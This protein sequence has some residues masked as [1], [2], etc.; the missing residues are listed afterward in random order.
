ML[1]VGLAPCVRQR[2]DKLTGVCK[3]WHLELVAEW[4][5]P[6]HGGLRAVA[7]W[8]AINWTPMLC[9][10]A[11]LHCLLWTWMSGAA[12]VH[13]ASCHMCTRP[14][15]TCRPARL[16]PPLVLLPPSAS[17]SLHRLVEPGT[18]SLA[19]SQRSQDFSREGGPMLCAA[20]Q[21]AA[22]CVPP[23]VV[24]VALWCSCTV[25]CCWCWMVL[26]L[27]ALHAPVHQ[28]MSDP[29][30]CPSPLQPPPRPACARPCTTCS[31]PGA[32]RATQTGRATSTG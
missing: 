30:P 12:H 10:P 29:P 13:E 6:S 15:A 2:H 16:T 25:A 22:T 11:T 32:R 1:H 14:P 7:G 24:P 17:G 31:S 3:P 5:S 23:A 19:G 18:P 28:P 9:W 26:V 21:P 27:H 8:L 20:L 4:Q